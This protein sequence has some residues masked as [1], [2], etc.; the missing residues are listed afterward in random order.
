MT[1]DLAE[2]RRF[3]EELDVRLNRCDNGEGT[4]C[5]NLDGTLQEYAILCRD[6]TEQVR[7]WRRAIF[8]GRAAFD[9]E[10]EYLWLSQGFEL[11]RRAS[12]LWD[13]GQDR[14][15]DCFVLENGAPLGAAIWQLERVLRHWTPPERALSPAARHGISIPADQLSE[16]QKRLA[17]LPS[18]PATWQPADPRLQKLFQKLHP[19]NSQAP[20]AGT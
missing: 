11:H 6:F 14:Q 2:V 16:A 15:Y 18:L 20:R 1:F 8:Y 4:E 17:A 5:T 10:V 9:P 12:E 13:K 19:R 7:E 3:T